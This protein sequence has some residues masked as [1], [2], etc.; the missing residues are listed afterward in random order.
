MRM[1]LVIMA[2]AGIL[3]ACAATDPA[4]A[5]QVGAPRVAAEE[6]QTTP[7]VETVSGATLRRRLVTSAGGL[8]YQ[9]AAVATPHLGGYV[10][11]VAVKVSSADGQTHR[12]PDL[13][14]R[15]ATNV[16]LGRKGLGGCSKRASPGVNPPQVVAPRQRVELVLRLRPLTDPPTYLPGARLRAGVGLFDVVGPQGRATQPAIATVELVV[17]G[18]RAARLM[19]RA[20]VDADLKRRCW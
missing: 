15:R 7:V 13:P 4:K 6:Q 19:L 8:R 5:P 9:V 3:S 11:D 1:R 12:F 16:T 10:I 18:A 14:L 17:I 2:G 20:G